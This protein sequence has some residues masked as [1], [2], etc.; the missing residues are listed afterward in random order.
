MSDYSDNHRI[1]S[2]SEWVDYIDVIK[3]R[4]STYYCM[5][6]NGYCISIPK[7]FDVDT[8]VWDEC[9]VVKSTNENEP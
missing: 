8:D 1:V 5:I 3:H 2:S 4:E 7:P 6:S 9:S